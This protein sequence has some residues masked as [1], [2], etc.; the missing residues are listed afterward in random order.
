M[1]TSPKSNGAPILSMLNVIATRG[2]RLGSRGSC[3]RRTRLPKVRREWSWASA[4][5]SR[6]VR[7]CSAN[8]AA[9]S[10]RARKRNGADA[11]R[12]ERGVLELRLAGERDADDEVRLAGEA[13][14]EHLERREQRREER[15]SERRSGALERGVQLVVDPQVLAAAAVGLRGR[16]GSGEREVED[17]RS[18]GILRG[19]V[20]LVGSGRRDLIVA[21]LLGDVLLDRT[22][23]GRA[24][25]GYRRSRRRRAARGPRRGRTTTSRRTR[26]GAR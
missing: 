18:V 13:V 12:D 8:G 2:V 4:R 24:A 10:R 9:G 23:R 16:A 5:S 26:C 17:R 19:P 6:T 20:V 21:R 11:V 25:P 3:S 7:R 14:H 15:G 22:R 1:V